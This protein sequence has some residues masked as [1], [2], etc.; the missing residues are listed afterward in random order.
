[1]ME[2]NDTAVKGLLKVIPS[3]FGFVA[4]GVTPVRKEARW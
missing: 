3:L 4:R 1:M 2:R